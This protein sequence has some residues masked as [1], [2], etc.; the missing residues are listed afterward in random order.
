MEQEIAC[1]DLSEFSYFKLWMLWMNLQKFIM[2]LFTGTNLTL[3]LYY[4]SDASNSLY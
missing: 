2:D 3:F 1:T 4:A